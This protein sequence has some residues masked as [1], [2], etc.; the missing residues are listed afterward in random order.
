MINMNFNLALRHLAHQK[1]YATLN[2]IGLAAGL[3][4]MLLAVLYWQD[5]RRYDLF[6][7]KTPQLFRVTAASISRETGNLEKTGGTRQV[8][9]PAFKAEIPEI[10][11]MTRLLGGDIKGDVRYE[12]HASKLQMLFVDDNFL[13]VFSFPLLHGNPATALKEINAIVLTEASALKLFGTTDALGKLLHL[14]ADPS[15]ERLGNKPMVVTGVVKDPPAQSSVQFE[16]LLPMRFMQLSFTDEAWLGGYLG[17]FVHLQQSADIQQI[18]TKLDAV[19]EKYAGAEIKA[20]GF[21]PQVHHSL[22]NIADIHLNPLDGVWNNWNE[23]GVSGGSRPIYSN[24]F[25]GIAFFILLLASINFV[26]ISIAASFG[27]AKETAVRKLNGS[28]RTS[29]FGQFMGESALLC[30]LTFAIALL[31]CCAVL[32]VFNDLADKKIVLRDAFDWK[33]AAG[34]ALV[35]LLNVSLSGL[36][37]AWLL[38]SFAPVEVLY[39]RNR[40][41]RQLRT[42]K[43]LVVL[44][45]ALAFLLAVATVIFWVQM[46]FIQRK[47][48]GY[49]PEL[50]VQTYISGN[51]DTRPI[52]QFLQNETARYPCFEGISYGTQFGNSGMET[53]VEGHRK[54]RAVYQ[55][56]DPSFLS[57][58]GIRLREGANFTAP[59]SREVLVNETFVR[60]SGLQNPIGSQVV[61][62]EDYAG[63]PAP[64]TIAGVLADFHFE[65]LRKPVQPLVLFQTTQWGGG[66]WLKIN[67]EKSAEA[68][69]VFEK[70]YH[71]AMPGAVYE[72]HFMSALNARAYDREQRWKNIIGIA[73]ALALLICCLGLFGLSHLSAAQRAKE[74]SIRKVAGAS[75]ADIVLL[76]TGHFL[77]LV[78]IAMALATPVALLVMQQWLADFAY[79]IEIKAWMFA[80]AGAVAVTIALLTVGYQSV[81]AALADPVQALRSI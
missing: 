49:Q 5:E 77:I 75:V 46:D 13:E 20:S 74:V 54:I 35:F 57:V 76:L 17:T 61:L 32:P 51:R 69:A 72:W 4:C 79:R 50:V 63:G 71:Q 16:V 45:F 66:V 39:S 37:P 14:D 55:D 40:S 22:Q 31:F 68:L 62:H 10:Q 8:H 34:F 80:A 36:Y 38:S 70:L 19:F 67:R 21:D 28:S 60:E 15:A 56:A 78:L 59:N 2:V 33:L 9:G 73:A 25:L 29:I 58:M 24:L 47:D 52:E 7:E 23:C 30:G 44:Q 48:L 27:R 64:Y 3:A 6:H 81:K 42:G 43:A 1:Q 41:L 26:N 53:T 12:D 18:N 11:A 65:S